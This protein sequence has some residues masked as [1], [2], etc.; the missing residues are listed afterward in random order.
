MVFSLVWKDS[1]QAW[2]IPASR[3][4]QWVAVT[5]TSN[6]LAQD[7]NSGRPANRLLALVILPIATQHQIC[8]SGVP[9]TCIL[10][11]DITSASNHPG[12]LPRESP[13]TG[14]FVGALDPSS[15]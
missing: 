10:T 3:R 5:I 8:L 9:V 13:H 11:A 6:I 7:R 2:G 15:E 14:I 4:R 1:S 12:N